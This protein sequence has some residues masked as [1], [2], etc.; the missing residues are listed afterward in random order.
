VSGWPRVKLGDVLRHVPRPVDVRF[1]AMYREIGIR[2][3][4]KGL[5]HKV[6]VSGA[7]LGDK[8]VFF[9]EPGDFVLNIVFAWEGAV[10]LA[11]ERERGM[12]ASHR[13]PTF[14][15]DEQRLDLRFLL[16]FFQTRTGVDLMG[17]VS[18]GGAGRN[19]TLNRTAF[20]SLE[21]PLPPLAEQQR[22]A[23]IVDQAASEVERSEQ[24]LSEQAREGEALLVSMAHRTDLTATEKSR[25]GWLKV[26]LANVMR[27][28]LNFQRVDSLSSYP[29][30]GI[31]S[32]AKGLFIKPPIAGLMTSAS[33]LN[34]V[35][36]GQFIY[37]RLF[38][39]EG[40]YGRVTDEFDGF[41]VSNEYPTF[42]CDPASL[43]PETLVAYLKP[44][45]MW[46]RIAEGSKGLGDR[47]QRVQPEQL[48]QHELWLPPIDDQRL[49][50]AVSRQ[51]DML[52]ATQAARRAELDALLPAVLDRA[53]AGAL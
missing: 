45:S 50:V 7:E 1:D 42:D 2:S 47:R 3:H 15:S 33:S 49:L 28:R 34:R 38:A 41:F 39:F 46:R 14:R 29:N 11:S 44:S 40:A 16:L 52:K 8:R 25:R 19:R 18:P 5:F 4:G 32:F 6:P 27:L 51:H 53:F 22:L 23:A 31:Y 30:L 12:I 35:H 13:F 24:L 37:S 26:K 17:R 36:A 20:L 21:I 9:I 43:L 10:A 48:L